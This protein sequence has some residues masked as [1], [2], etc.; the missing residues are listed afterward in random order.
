MDRLSRHAAPTFS[1]VD[2]LSSQKAL[3]A[4]AS[5]YQA[6]L[7]TLIPGPS[8]AKRAKGVRPSSP[9]PPLPQA[10]EGELG[11]MSAKKPH[12]GLSSL[13]STGLLGELAEAQPTYLHTLSRSKGSTRC[14]SQ[15]DTVSRVVNIAE[16]LTPRQAGYALL[17]SRVGSKRRSFA[18][19]RG[20][21]LESTERGDHPLA[22]SAGEGAGG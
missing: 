2:V 11:C 7:A 6:Q 4:S 1:G 21:I 12:K 9:R 3:S 17:K 8:P 15:K 14:T 13:A 18:Y 16:A 19:H 20:I 22:R 10:G 5:G